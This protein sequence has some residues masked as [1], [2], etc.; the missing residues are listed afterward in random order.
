MLLHN[1]FLYEITYSCEFYCHELNI[2]FFKFLYKVF[3]QFDFMHY[4][5][6][7]I[8]NSISDMYI[9]ED[10]NRGLKYLLVLL[11]QIKIFLHITSLYW[12]L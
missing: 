2:T 5:L 6:L 3:L 11:H 9:A 4:L 10:L 7:S 8:V 1:Q 12:H